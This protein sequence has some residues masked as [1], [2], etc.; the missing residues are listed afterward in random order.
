MST[1]S[2]I[3]LDNHDE[4]YSM[5]VHHDGYLSGVGR[6]LLHHYKDI[7]KVDRLMD[8]GWVSSLRDEIDW[9][10]ES[11]H[12]IDK[13]QVHTYGSMMQVIEEFMSS[14]AEYLYVFN[15]LGWEYMTKDMD[16]PILLV[17]SDVSRH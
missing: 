15:G 16:V 6:R 4:Y 11:K 5:R 8:L 13:E 10:P 17:P 1:R 14:D 3:A 12:S 2:M 7:E 9:M